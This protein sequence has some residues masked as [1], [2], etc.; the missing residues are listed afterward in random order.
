MRRRRLTPQGRPLRSG[1]VPFDLAAFE[2]D[3]GIIVIWDGVFETYAPH[4]RHLREAIAQIR[5]L[6]AAHA[7]ERAYSRL[8]N[9]SVHQGRVAR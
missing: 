4:K 3:D 8:A 7:T 1:R 2:R 5:D 9:V 6:Q